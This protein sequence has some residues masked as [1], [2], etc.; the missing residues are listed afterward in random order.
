MPL[1]PV[2]WVYAL[3]ILTTMAIYW[4]ISG[5]E[6]INFDDNEYVYE[7]AHVQ[8]GVTLEN[9]VWAF[10][11]TV[12]ANW[13]PVTMLSHMLDVHLFGLQPGWHHL[14]NLLFHLLNTALL[15]HL[16]HKLTRKMWPSAFMAALFALH[17]LHVE[18]VAWISE[19]KDVLSTFFWILTMLQYSRYVEKPGIIRYLM[20]IFCFITGLMAKPML[21]TLPFVL[22]LLDL[23]PLARLPWTGNGI[24]CPTIDGPHDRSAHDRLDARRYPPYGLFKNN[25]YMAIVIEKVPFFIVVVAFC[26]IAFFVQR[27]DGAVA[28]V[29]LIPLESRI[30][31]AIVSYGAY[32]IQMIWPFRL[33]IFYPF[34]E[35]IP[36]WK[37]WTSAL[38]LLLISLFAFRRVADRPWI[39]F[40]W[41]W[42]LGTLVPVIGLVQIGSQSMADRYTYVPFI[43]IFLI[44]A[45]ETDRLLQQFR[46]TRT[47][48]VSLAC[49]LLTCLSLL[50]WIQARQW[51]TSVTLFAYATR[52]TKDNSLAHNNLGLALLDRNRFQEAILHLSLST[53]LKPGNAKLYNNL[54]IAL[55]KAGQIEMAEKAFVHATEVNPG[56]W[57]A[58]VNLGIVLSRRGKNRQALA[59]FQKALSLNPHQGKAHYNMAMSLEKQNRIEEALYHYATA[60]SIDPRLIEALNRKKRLEKKRNRIEM[61]IRDIK[62]QLQR[63]P[64]DPSLLV[65]IGNLHGQKGAIDDAVAYYKQ[66]LEIQP[67]HYPAKMQL[68]FAYARNGAYDQAISWYRSALA[69]TPENST[70]YYNIACLYSIQNK[71][72]EAMQ[73]LQQAVDNGYQDWNAIRTDPD[74]DSIRSLPEFE[75]RFQEK[76]LKK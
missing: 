45:W 11:S 1:R 73:W 5:H 3:L 56:Y 54:G 20:T 17:P 55:M 42:Y 13:H 31:N 39:S 22:L 29:D 67:D 44:I 12:G 6:F 59:H 33:A 2:V 37:V 23:W 9:I 21:V 76:S 25:P 35:I 61:A 26:C 15:F 62:E 58:H 60:V 66:A 68:A 8:Q 10:T 51:Q 14:V 63:N 53:W 52:V 49:L 70:I 40:G 69:S 64:K 27:S 18:S 74:L 41:L 65:E 47:V 28:A 57:N 34:P 4:Q 24:Y 50:T 19:R 30:F 36:V 38:F 46:P 71:Q 43:G 75:K 7:N 72:P 16:F 32:L 48:L